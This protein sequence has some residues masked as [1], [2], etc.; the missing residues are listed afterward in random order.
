[1][2]RWYDWMLLALQVLD[3]ALVVGYLWT[4]EQVAGIGGTI[5]ANIADA[6]H[7]TLLVTRHTT[8]IKDSSDYNDELTRRSTF[9]SAMSWLT[10]KIQVR[11]E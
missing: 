8:H 6:H 1:M 5:S 4:A 3:M 2:R 9:H 7:K 10:G 11:Q